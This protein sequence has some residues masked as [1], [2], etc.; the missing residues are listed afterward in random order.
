MAGT[1]LR[2]CEG[3]G[4]AGADA[5]VWKSEDSSGLF[6]DVYSSWLSAEA[7]GSRSSIEIPHVT[8]AGPYRPCIQDLHIE[9]PV[10]VAI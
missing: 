5:G 9:F 6:S 4:R 10:P 2:C 1:K 8:A 7:L 3:V